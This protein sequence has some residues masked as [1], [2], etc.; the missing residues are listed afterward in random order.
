MSLSTA[1]LKSVTTKSIAGVE[2]LNITQ[3][4]IINDYNNYAIVIISIKF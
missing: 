2:G 1:T 3:V 4:I